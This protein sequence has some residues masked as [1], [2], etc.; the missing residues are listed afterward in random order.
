[1][2]APRDLADLELDPRVMLEMG[3]AVLDRVVA[4][5]A[6]L[7]EQPARGDMEGIADF[8]RSMREPAPE[9][10]AEL[11]SLLAPLFD[12]WVHRTYNSAHPGYLAYVAGGGIFPAALA[13]LIADGLNRYTGVWNAS[14]P[15]VQ[16]EDNVLEWLREWMCFPTGTRGILTSGGSM[17]SFSAIVTARDK[18][19]GTELRQ[20]T[21]YT[22]TQAHHCIGKAAQLAGILPD[23]VR[24]ID[25][26]DRFRLRTDALEAAIAAD[27]AAGLRPFAVV[28]AAG[29]VN[30]G[31]VDP[32]DA[33]AD[34]CEREGLWHHCDGAYGGF[35]YMCPSLRP[36]LS[37]L[38]RVDSLTLDPHKGLFLP[39]GNGALLVKDGAALRAAHE[40][41][42]GYLPPLPDGD[43]H[44]PSQYSPELSRPFRGL[45]VWL[46]LKLYGAARFRAVLEEK[47]TLAVQCAKRLGEIDG[48]DIFDEPPL[49]L[50][51]F[52]VHDDD[53]STKAL[54]EHVNAKGRV[55]VSGCTI[56]DRFYGRVCVLC[57]R[58]RQLHIDHFIEDAREALSSSTALSPPQPAEP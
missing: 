9:D 22:S 10:G 39:Y 49:S 47:R 14:P 58:T 43:F 31:A 55:M 45:R 27:R 6:S 24:V 32:I 17:A 8:C 42:A 13:D 29:T 28:S 48:I 2:S 19:L 30:T 5:I 15:L 7:G 16:L 3:R 35:F 41:H 46:P 36:L 12:D 52:R 57:F 1:V 44:N 56:G 18:L 25:V 26:D 37:G 33:I 23:R 40:G 54:L 50:F 20:G 21:L 4:H 38:P 51:A 34:I 53:V 11:E